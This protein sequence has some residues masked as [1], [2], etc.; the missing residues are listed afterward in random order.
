MGRIVFVKPAENF[1]GIL[2]IG[3]NIDHREARK[4]IESE[5]I[6]RSSIRLF[7]HDPNKW[8]SKLE[9]FKK[10]WMELLE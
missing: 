9:E 4:L 3:K 10:K 7:F 8:G 6:S 5:R 2:E 1:E